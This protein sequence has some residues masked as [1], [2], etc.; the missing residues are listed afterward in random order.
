MG[1][2]EKLLETDMEKLQSNNAKSYE[3]KRLSKALGA[4]FVILCKP[5]T[6]EQVMHVGEISKTNGEM[7]TNAILETCT[8][9]GRKLNHAPLLEKFKAV[10]GRELVEKLLLP[11]EVYQLYDFINAMSGY[12][13]DAVKEVK[14]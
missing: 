4:P 9:D 11:G 6:N 12:G 7:K 13:R 2:L 10:S 1:I 8:I 14:N 5:L 3:M